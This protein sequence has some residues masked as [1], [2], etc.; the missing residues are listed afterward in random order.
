MAQTRYESRVPKRRPHFDMEYLRSIP[1]V[2]K[3]VQTFCSLGA[4][5]TIVIVHYNWWVVY[6]SALGTIVAFVVSLV[7]LSMYAYHLI[8]VTQASIDWLKYESIYD[9]GFCLL[10]LF[11][12]GALTAGAVIWG[13]TTLFWGTG[14]VLCL[15]GCVAFGADFYFKYKAWRTGEDPQEPDNIYHPAHANFSGDSPEEHQLKEDKL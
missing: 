4:F 7:L 10:F 6:I 12:F 15:I 2:L 11:S 14:A 13:A 5:I 9:G 3:I 1:G 8:E